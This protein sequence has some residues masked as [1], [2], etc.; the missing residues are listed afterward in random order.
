MIFNLERVNNMILNYKKI[1][2]YRF[3]RKSDNKYM[4]V[5]IKFSP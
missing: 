3:I 4:K 1:S 2:T 5:T